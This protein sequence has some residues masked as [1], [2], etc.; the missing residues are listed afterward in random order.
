MKKKVLVTGVSGFVGQHCAV[1]LLKH[2]YHVKGSLRDLSKGDKIKEAISKVVDPKDQ[3]EFCILDLTK[4]EGWEEAMKGC[5]FL[6]HV[7]SP[8]IFKQTD[9]EN[10]LIKPAVDGT[11]R[12]LKAAQKSEVKRV[13]LTSS[14]TAMSGHMYSGEFTPNDW[15]DLSDKNLS[16]YTRSKTIA[17]KAAWDFYNNQ[18]TGHK[19]ELVVINPGGITGPTLTNNL[20]G[21][22]MDTL[23]QLITG[24]MSMIPD[25]SFPMVDVRDVAALHVQALTNESANGKRFIAA[26]KQPVHYMDIAKMLKNNGYDKVSTKKAPLFLLKMIGFVN[27][28]VKALLTLIGKHLSADNSQTISVFNWEPMSMEKSALD[29]AKSVEI[30][31]NKKYSKG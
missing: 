25:V 13:V 14:I 5:E 15:T 19:I 21:T 7:A 11:L 22:S 16:T 27:K 17:E 26:S 4:D 23:V 29:M 24:K 2:G 30:A 10:E 28:E 18:K 31:L 12:A 1:E 9:D 3:L 8:F 6:L 20:E